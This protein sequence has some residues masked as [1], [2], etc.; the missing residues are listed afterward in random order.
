MDNQ[1]A[2]H[3]VTA[4]LSTGQGTN[5][6]GQTVLRDVMPVLDC[7]PHE[8]RIYVVNLFAFVWVMDMEAEVEPR[9]FALNSEI[10]GVLIT[11]TQNYPLHFKGRGGLHMEWLSLEITSPSIESGRGWAFVILDGKRVSELPFDIRVHAGDTA[12]ESEQ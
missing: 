2:N 11:N 12:M 8:G 1:P 10:P 3:F 4:I 5:D 6:R 9:S 7:Y